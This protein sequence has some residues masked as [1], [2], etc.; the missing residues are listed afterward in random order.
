MLLLPSVGELAPNRELHQA[1]ETP[2]PLRDPNGTIVF[3]GFPADVL[4]A[5]RLYSIGAQLI[6]WTAIG[7]VFAP[8]AERLLDPNA[9]RTGQV[10]ETAPLS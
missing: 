7:L 5:F 10:R 4:Y 9:G 2:G 6:L 3:P 8:L 1:T